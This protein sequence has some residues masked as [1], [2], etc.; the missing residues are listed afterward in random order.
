MPDGV[1]QA[2]GGVIAN[3]DEGQL[4]M[5]AMKVMVAML[6]ALAAAAPAPASPP[7]NPFSERLQR[8]DELRRYT[9][10]RRAVLDSGEPCKRVDR[11]GISGRYKN[12]VMWTA[13]CVP[14]GNYALFIGPDASVQVRDCAELAKL[15][16]PACRLPPAHRTQ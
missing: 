14:G 11:A 10:L 2:S 16:L 3:K 9:I 7:P 4:R 8:L 6:A 1:S 15:G 12:L 13:H 5:T